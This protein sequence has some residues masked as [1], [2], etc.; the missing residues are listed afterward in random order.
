M[1][2]FATDGEYKQWKEALDRVVTDKVFSAR[3]TTN[4]YWSTYYSAFTAT[5]EK[6]HGVSMFV[7]QDPDYGRYIVR[8]EDIK[9]FE[10]WWKVWE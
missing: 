10:W 2:K 3:W 1:K 9:M 7:P 4:K 6:Y 5:E 8:N